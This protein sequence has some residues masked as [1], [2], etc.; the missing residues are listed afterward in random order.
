MFFWHPTH[1]KYLE[2][3]K[4]RNSKIFLT[5]HT[6]KILRVRKKRTLRYFFWTHNTANTS[7]ILRI[8]EKKGTLRCFSWHPTHPKILEFRKKRNSNFFWHPTHPKLS[9]FRK[10][11][12][13]SFLE[14]YPTSKKN[15]TQDH[16]SAQ[17]SKFSE[18]W[19]LGWYTTPPNS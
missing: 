18:F 6:S 4:K 2:F 3:R 7:K 12:T 5:P 17:N 11:R 15:A 10:K 14:L 8:P 1:P 16:F 13:K 19:N 9:E